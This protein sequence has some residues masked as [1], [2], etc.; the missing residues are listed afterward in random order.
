MTARI[1]L[2]SGFALPKKSGNVIG[3]GQY[4]LAVAGGSAIRFKNFYCLPT[5]YREVVL[6]RSKSGF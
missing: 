4:H 1:I 3:P 2:L 5:R 6:T